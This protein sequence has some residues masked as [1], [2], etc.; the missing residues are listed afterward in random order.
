MA[1][2]FVGTF[3]GNTVGAKP[4][5]RVCCELQ[6]TQE[7]NSKTNNK[8][9]FYQKRYYLEVTIAGTTERSVGISWGPNAIKIKDTG[10]YADSGWIDVGW[11]KKNETISC[12]CSA[13]YKV[14]ETEYRSILSYT[15]KVKP[16][17]YTVM[18]DA[19][20]G[21]GVP[22]AMSFEKGSSVK[23]PTT[24]PVAKGFYFVTWNTREDGFGVNYAPGSTYSQ[25]ANATLF[26]IWEKKKTTVTF[27]KNDEDGSKETRE[28]I[29]GEP[30][31]KFPAFGWTRSGYELLG[32][33]KTA[34]ATKEDYAVDYTVTDSF[35]ES[36]D[37][38]L[39][40]YAVW[41]KIESKI[42]SLQVSSGGAHYPAIGGWVKDGGDHCQITAIYVK[43]GGTYKII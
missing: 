28:Y 6:Y 26:A 32:Y 2:G 8:G 17:Y 31:V 19:N 40:L 13:V 1:D 9:K 43:D 42:S 16:D 25:N 38:T 33:A 15:Y 18:F 12:D 4:K 3:Y 35:I 24:I 39:N 7:D 41:S 23:I 21:F 11:K 22:S 20:G 10:I 36:T 5:Y 37:L 30:K 34:T 14:S 29:Y 27:H